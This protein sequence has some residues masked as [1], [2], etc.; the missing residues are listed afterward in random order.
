[1]RSL[2]EVFVAESVAAVDAIGR[3]VASQA[4][5]LVLG[6]VPAMATMS[7]VE[8]LG[9]LRP[10]FLPLPTPLEVLSRYDALP[11]IPSAAQ[12][13]FSTFEDHTLSISATVEC[14]M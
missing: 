3:E 2:Q 8:A 13:L 10:I 9:P 4:S 6:S 12:S 1:M 14:K 5:R 11:H 7:F